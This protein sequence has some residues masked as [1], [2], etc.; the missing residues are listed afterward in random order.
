[1]YTLNLNENHIVLE[2]MKEVELRIER[3][4]FDVLIIV[5]EGDTK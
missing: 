1:M 2:L 5:Y 4:E 3:K